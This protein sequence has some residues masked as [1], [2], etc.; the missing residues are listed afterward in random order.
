MKQW[1]N[2]EYTSKQRELFDRR[3]FL[4]QATGGLGSIALLSM[5]SQDGLLPQALGAPT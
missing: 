3:N 4:M 1:E 2:D 5:L